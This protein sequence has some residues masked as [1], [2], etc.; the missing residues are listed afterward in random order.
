MLKKFSVKQCL[1]F[2]MLQI[3]PF[4]LKNNGVKECK[5]SL[6]KVFAQILYPK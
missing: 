5:T 2:F 4:A 6:L 3:M 1:K